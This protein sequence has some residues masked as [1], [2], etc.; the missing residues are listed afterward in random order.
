MTVPLTPSDLLARWRR[1]DLVRKLVGGGAAALIIRIL[2]AGLGY[3]LIVVL[4]RLMDTHEYGLYAVGISLATMLAVA[5]GLGLPSA[6]LRFWPQHIVQ[7]RP[8]LAKGA[9]VTGYWLTGC[10]AFGAF[11]LLVLFGSLADTALTSA[12][13][14]PYVATALVAVALLLAEYQS[15]VLRA[16]GPIAWALAPKFVIWRLAVIGA[17]LLI[18]SS[19]QT[20]TAETV[21]W[22]SGGVLLTL[23]VAQVFYIWRTLPGAV[24]RLRTERAKGVWFRTTVGLWGVKIFGAMFPHFSVVVVGAL[25]S[26]EAGGMFFAIKRTATLFEIPL[27]AAAVSAPP[28]IS[29]AYHSGDRAKLQRISRIVVSASAIPILVGLF[30]VVGWGD[31]VLGLFGPEFRELHLAFAILAAGHVLGGLF[32]PV[33]ALLSMTGRERAYLAVLAAAALISVGLLFLLIPVWGI[34]GAAVAGA[35]G[36]IIQKAALWTVVR[37]RIGVDASIRAALTG[38]SKVDSA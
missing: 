32:G 38:A 31:A 29:S 15:G 26:P 20:L 18:A 23:S 4:A 5:A 22:L 14:L 36:Q 24:W 37:V 8:A 12:Q 9:L 28:M 13:V 21:L 30:L 34:L 11:G 27:Y 10:A 35:A 17:V 2:G 6:V 7:D 33:D 3:G 1:S 16:L 25:M 19:G